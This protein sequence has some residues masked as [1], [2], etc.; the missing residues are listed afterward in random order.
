[1]AHIMAIPV[2]T[3]TTSVIM[4]DIPAPEDHISHQKIPHATAFWYQTGSPEER[5]EGNTSVYQQYRWRY[6]Q[7]PN[8]EQDNQG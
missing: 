3:S 8:I 5:K 1:M 6:L 4:V 7:N 2:D